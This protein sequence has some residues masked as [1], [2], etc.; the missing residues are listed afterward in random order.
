MT[1]DASLRAALEGHLVAL[2]LADAGTRSDVAVATAGYRRTEGSFVADGFRA[3]D[4]ILVA[5]FSEAGNDGAA[6]LRAVTAEELTVDRALTPEAAG[7]P[8]GIVATLPA[9]RKFDGQ[10]FVRPAAA[11]WVRVALKPVGANVAA[12]GAGGLLRQR[13]TLLVDLCEPVA[14]GFGLARLERL[15]AGLRGHFRAG[16]AIARD[17]LVVRIL[18]LRRGAVQ[19]TRDFLSLPVSV[20]WFCDAA[21]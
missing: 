8:V 10:P 17:G 12:F 2:R 6:I 11:P 3:G 13:G 9:A 21:N 5:G 1:F 15:A 14:D 18:G 7:P 16:A 4:T 20:E 19:E